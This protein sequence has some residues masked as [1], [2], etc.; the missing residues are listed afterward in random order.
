MGSFESDNFHVIGLEI[1]FIYLFLG[2]PFVSSLTLFTL[3]E[4][5]V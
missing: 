2:L 1:P 5:L 3:R 4:Q